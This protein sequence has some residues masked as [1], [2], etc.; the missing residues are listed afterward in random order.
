VRIALNL[1]GLQPENV[2]IHLLKNEQR[3][4]EYLEINP[5]GL[6]PT[7]VDGYEVIPQSLAI[8]EYLDEKHPNPPLLPATP[9][10]RA[11]VRSLAL[12]VACDIHPLNNLRV[13]KYLTGVLN[14]SEQQKIEWY[15]HWVHEGLL[16]LET[17]LA[18]DPHTGQF[19]HGVTPTLADICLIP[20]MANARRVSMDLALYPTLMRIEETCNRLPAFA[21]AAPGKQPDAA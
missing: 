6:I 14:V 18:S 20:Q 12:A 9:E 15:A 11:R 19:C 8:M 4:T 7:L 13:L 5:Q 2:F 16:A 21:D 1:K 17:R 3:A 10:A